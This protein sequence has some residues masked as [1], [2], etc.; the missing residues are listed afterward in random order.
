MKLKKWEGVRTGVFLCLTLAVMVLIFVLSHQSGGTSAKVSNTIADAVG[1]KPT[2]DV[3]AS[4]VP[5]LAGFS[6]RKLA[7]IGLFMALAMSA[8]LFYMSLTKR[9]TWGRRVLLVSLAALVTGVL[10]AVSDEVHQYFIPYRF[11]SAKDILIDSF[12]V[13]LGIPA[14]IGVWHLTARLYQMRG[15]RDTHQSDKE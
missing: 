8:A 7:H 15:K 13:V 3:T 4:N 2:E 10:Y 11:F 14:A 12:G 5:V 1:V 6:L 9:L